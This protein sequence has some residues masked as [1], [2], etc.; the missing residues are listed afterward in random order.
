MKIETDGVAL[1]RPTREIEDS[2]RV[3]M[4]AVSPSFPPVG[5]TP[6]EI[7]DR[8]RVQMGAVSPSFPPVR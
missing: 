8:N 7:R 5:A 2:K 4:G 6:T 3:Q 1:K